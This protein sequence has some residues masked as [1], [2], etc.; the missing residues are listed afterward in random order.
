MDDILKTQHSFAK[1]A[2]TEPEHRFMNLY[3]LLKRDD[4]LNAALDKVLSNVGARTGGIDGITLKHFKQEGFREEFLANLQAELATG[5]YQPQPVKRQ[6]IAKSNG[7]LRPLGIPTIRDRV[8]QQ[9][10]KML[11]EPIFESDFLGCSTGFRPGRRTMDAIAVCYR[12]INPRNGY[13]WVIEGDIRSYFDRVNHD[14]LLKLVARRVADVKVLNLIGRFLNAGVMENQVFQ[15]SPEGTPQGG[16]LSPLLANIYLHELDRWWWMRYGQL[17]RHAK[18]RRRKKGQTNCVYTRYA[19]DWIV[20]CNG[21]KAQAEAIRDEIRQFLQD[22]LKLELSE[23]KTVVTHACDG[24]DFLGFHIQ[25]YPAHDG[26]KA[27]TLARPSDKSIERLK[28][29]VRGM[30]DRKGFNDNPMFKFMA[31]NAVL[32]G[33]MNYYRHCSTSKIASWLDHWVHLRVAKWLVTRHE[34]CYREILKQYLK[35]QGSRKNFAVKRTDGSD[36]FLY[37]MR[38]V[39]IT[40]YHPITRV[41][42]YLQAI[43]E[44]DDVVTLEIPVPDD[45]WNGRAE[46]GYNNWRNVR[47]EVLERD[48]HRCTICGSQE[49]LDVHHIKPKRK[50]GQDVPENLETVCEKCHVARGGYGRPRKNE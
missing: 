48:G 24:F 43:P 49:N 42:P 33:W 30:T 31:L 2:M 38:D 41:N 29:K 13:Y 6:Y 11:L 39:P 40:P 8:G 32:R 26:H 15:R 28:E 25:H 12:L 1:K 9:L 27:I 16:I 17:D 37:M 36:L 18:E 47:D 5:T 22:T 3:H 44:V 21:T 14:I 45:P 20:L 23:E 34:S 19:D 4:W 10:L 46:V 7:K 50:G 35:Q